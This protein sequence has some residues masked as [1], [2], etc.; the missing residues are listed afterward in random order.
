MAL[1]KDLCIFLNSKIL[2]FFY[3]DNIIT[4]YY[5]LNNAN[6]SDFTIKLKNRFK[7]TGGERLFI[8]LNI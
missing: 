5:P 4:A 6:Y 2:V 3:I 8:F 7:L 1:N